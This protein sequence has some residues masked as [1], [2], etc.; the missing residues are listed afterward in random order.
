MMAAATAAHRPPK[1]KYMDMGPQEGEPDPSSLLMYPTQPNKKKA[2]F[3]H[4]HYHHDNVAN[5]TTSSGDSAS[6]NKNDDYRQIISSSPTDVLTHPVATTT[7]GIFPVKTLPPSLK[8]ISDAVKGLH[9]SLRSSVGGSRLAGHQQQPA[10]R[11]QLVAFPTEALYVLTCCVK[12][13]SKKKILLANAAAAVAN[14]SSSTNHDDSAAANNSS[15]DCFGGKS[16]YSSTSCSGGGG[17]D[18]NIIHPANPSLEHLLSRQTSPIHHHHQ[19]QQQGEEKVQLSSRPSVFVIDSRHAQHYCQFSHPKMF[20]IR[21]KAKQASHDL[22]VQSSRSSSLLAPTT[23]PVAPALEGSRDNIMNHSADRSSSGQDE[24]QEQQQEVRLGSTTNT[25][26]YSYAPSSPIKSSLSPP[27]SSSLSTGESST[28]KRDM[29]ESTSSSSVCRLSMTPK[30]VTAENPI[31]P[32]SSASSSVATVSPIA[33]KAAIIAHMNDDVK[34]PPSRVPLSTTQNNHNHHPSNH[35]TNKLLAV[36]FSESYE[37]FSRLAN[38]FWPGPMIIYAPA[39]MI[40]VGNSSSGCNNKEE[41][42]STTPC[43]LPKSQHGNLSRSSSNS[44]SSSSSCPSLPSLTNLFSLEK[45]EAA[46]AA[47]AGN[48]NSHVSVLPPSVLIP[49]TN[50][51]LDRD[52]D[53]TNTNNDTKEEEFFIGMQCPSH[54]LARRILTEIHRPLRRGGGSTTTTSSSLPM[55]HSISTESFASFSSLDTSNNTLTHRPGKQRHIRCGIAVV[56]SYIAPARTGCSIDDDN[57]SGREEEESGVDTTSVLANS[58]TNV[59]RILSSTPSPSS[60]SNLKKR[61][62]EQIYVVNGED[63]THDYFS[64]PTCNY[65]GVSPISLVVDGANRTIYLLRHQNGKGCDSNFSKETIYRALLQPPSSFKSTPVGHI[66]VDDGSNS[67]ASST[68]DIDRVITAVLSRWKIV[69]R[70]V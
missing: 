23:A 27:V 46:A 30:V 52:G 50:L 59:T 67:K 37:A 47:A 66:H 25:T 16:S 3:H 34:M 4:H 17:A 9:S 24:Q 11:P 10:R 39:R 63:T 32:S 6:K 19:Q 42:T 61:G 65:G 29:V 56:G 40:S 51:L 8:G 48:Y 33:N 35:N 54:P 70:R 21:P 60:S 58:A 44:S 15:D 13:T 20:A 7:A 12:T 5:N 64:V 38:K 36:N 26:S 43:C 2:K 57:D 49:S 53:T 55:K 28:P 14:S 31:I 41:G 18:N 45:G 68:K 69:E 22:A 62:T 1:T